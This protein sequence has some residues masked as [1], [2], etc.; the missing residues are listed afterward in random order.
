MLSIRLVAA[1]GGLGGGIIALIVIGVVAFAG[2]FGAAST[3]R[4]VSRGAKAAAM[5][6]SVC[7]MSHTL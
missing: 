6:V 5:H 4:C 2:G 3:S 7:V 1:G